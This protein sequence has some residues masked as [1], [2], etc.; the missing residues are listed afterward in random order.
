MGDLGVVEIES[1]HWVTGGEEPFAHW[2]AHVAEA[3]K[4]KGVVVTHLAPA[5]LY[6]ESLVLAVR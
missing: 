1:D 5:G 6:F 4:A 2:L 3:N